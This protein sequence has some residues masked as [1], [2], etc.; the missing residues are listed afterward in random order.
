MAG[1]IG[2][3]A[4]ERSHSVRQIG[5]RRSCRRGGEVAGGSEVADVDSPA[6]VKVE[7][8]PADM[9]PVH[10]GEG[11]VGCREGS[12]IDQHRRRT[13]LDGLTR[14][15]LVADHAD[16][17]FEFGSGGTV[18]RTPLGWEGA[19]VLNGPPIDGDLTGGFEAGGP[20]AGEG[21]ERTVEVAIDHEFHRAPDPIHISSRL[22]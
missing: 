12:G 16:L 5:R 8:L 9:G 17:A 15:E 7:H 19:V 13:Q 14:S 18:D 10:R 20:V 21:A 4:V 2:D 22:G 3:P 6:P 1:T 11:G